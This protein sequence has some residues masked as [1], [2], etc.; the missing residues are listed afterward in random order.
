MAVVEAMFAAVI[1]WLVL[2]PI[3]VEELGFQF[4]VVSFLHLLGSSLRHS[5]ILFLSSLLSL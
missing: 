3:V 2:M 4:L 5:F 1:W